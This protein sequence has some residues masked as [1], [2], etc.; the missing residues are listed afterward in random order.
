MRTVTF[1][2]RK[3]QGFLN[4]NFVN[5]FTNTTG[6]ATSGT[7]INH[8]PNDRAGNCV[9]GNGKQNV[10]TVFMTP[11]GEI[12]HVATGFLAAEDLHDEA[13]FA[14]NL[15]AAMQKTQRVVVTEEDSVGGDT[16]SNLVVD[17]HRKRL[18]DLGFS[19]NEIDPPSEM[20][21]MQ[22]LHNMMSNNAF[23][24]PTNSNG[25][26][27]RNANRTDSILGDVF[28]GFIKKQI[29]EDNQFSINHPL[30]TQSELEQ[31]PT[32]LVGNSKTFFSSSSFGN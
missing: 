9:R 23:T 21:R 14:L 31:D 28:Q 16:L 2:Q 4:N 15:F 10:Q 5:T 13:K 18:E 17:A 3:L 8:R 25:S 19:E 11:Q 7:S 26:S 29:L 27:T 1:S 30:I 6:D 12:F 24:F 32:K 22:N 20:A